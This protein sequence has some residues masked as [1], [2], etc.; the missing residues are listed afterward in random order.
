MSGISV[1]HVVFGGLV[2][3]LVINVG[4]T[5]LNGYLLMPHYAD[6]MMVYGV[7]E[8]PYSVP[9]FTVYGFVLGIAAIWLYAAVRPRFGAGPR[10][11]V[12]VGLFI[13][14]LYAGSFASFHLAIPLFPPVV[15]FGNLAWGLVE[16]PVAVLLGAWVY[17][18]SGGTVG[19]PTDATAAAA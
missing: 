13:W 2:T 9:I 17:R 12:M 3:G 7:P 19:H 18:E 1:K 4:E 6:R 11:A 15:P 10:T 16:G 5:V 8:S 14:V